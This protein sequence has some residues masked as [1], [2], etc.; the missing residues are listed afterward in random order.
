VH[1]LNELQPKR[2]LIKRDALGLRDLGPFLLTQTGSSLE[3]GHSSEIAKIAGP[4]SVGP[5]G[6]RSNYGV[7]SYRETPG[8]T[9]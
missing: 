6:N 2:S 1:I 3:S 8:D 9:E 4:A 5:V 7:E